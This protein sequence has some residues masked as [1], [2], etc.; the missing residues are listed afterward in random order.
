[1]QEP[2]SLS[3][4]ITI[5]FSVTKLFNLPYEQLIA[6]VRAENAAKCQQHRARLEEKYGELSNNDILLILKVEEDLAKCEGCTG[7]PCRKNGVD[8]EQQM[9]CHRDTFDNA[10]HWT[11]H[12]CQFARRAREQKRL[13]RLLR[14]SKIPNRYF[15]KTWDDYQVD[16]NNRDAVD[17]AKKTLETGDGAFLY[18]E[19]GAGKTFLASLIAKDYLKAGKSV[20]FIKVPRLLD[21]L[22][23][24]YNGKGTF[25]EAQLLEE[26]YTVDLLVL[27]DFGMEKPTKFAGATLCKI[28]D[29]RYD[30][31]GLT[32]IITS[33]Y[34]LDR[35]RTE[36][37]N[38]TDGANYNGSRIQDR[39]TEICKAILL[40]GKSRRNQQ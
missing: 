35:I 8:C 15:N 11:Q 6:Q 4:A 16:A 30:C 37:D 31:Y 25:T 9:E 21:D 19:R 39:C 36:L 3:N 40:K 14:G 29:A 17:F 22:R 18:G 24:T 5:A 34:S 12:I 38:A 32:T 1:M 28:I 33:N 23:D 10:F 20:T 2:Q 7:L 13:N 27:D 26:V